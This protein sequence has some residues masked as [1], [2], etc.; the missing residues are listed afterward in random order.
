MINQQLLLLSA[1]YSRSTVVRN[2][3][4]SSQTAWPTYLGHLSGLPPFCQL[5]MHPCVCFLSMALLLCVHRGSSTGFRYYYSNS[6]GD[7]TSNFFQGPGQLDPAY[8]RVGCVVYNCAT[9]SNQLRL[10]FGCK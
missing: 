3:H 4:N 5:L 10:L 1:D 2:C 6:N 8:T 9:A 7:G